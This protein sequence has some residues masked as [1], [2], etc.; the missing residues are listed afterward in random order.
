MTPPNEGAHDP[1]LPAPTAGA[2]APATE[3]AVAPEAGPPDDMPLPDHPVSPGGPLAT[4]GHA[5][6]PPADVPGAG[7]GQDVPQAGGAEAE[8]P[9]L[10]NFV[11]HLV[12]KKTVRRG[13]PLAAVTEDLLALTGGW[14]RRVGDQ[15]FCPTPEH[16][17]LWLDNPTRLFAW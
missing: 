17:V 1:T 10:R 16:E 5:P 3:P 4:E 13:R 14:P 8:A 7:P 2:L 6:A 12:G 9:A 15:L 11:E